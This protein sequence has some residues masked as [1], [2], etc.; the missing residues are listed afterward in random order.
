MRI[1]WREPTLERMSHREENAAT[2]P[3]ATSTEAQRSKTTIYFASG[4]SSEMGGDVKIAGR[5]KTCTY[6]I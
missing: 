5:R 4:C 1:F 2:S 6:I 3:E